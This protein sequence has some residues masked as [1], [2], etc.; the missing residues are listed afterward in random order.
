MS[1]FLAVVEKDNNALY[2]DVSMEERRMTRA[3]IR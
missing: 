2:K 1:E 3:N